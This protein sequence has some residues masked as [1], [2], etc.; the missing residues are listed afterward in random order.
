MGFVKRRGTTKSN[1]SVAN[2]EALKETF[3]SDIATTVLME[4]IPADLIFICLPIY[5]GGI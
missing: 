5:I 4:D 3:L 1:V 2:F